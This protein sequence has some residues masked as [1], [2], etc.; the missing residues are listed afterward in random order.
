MCSERWQVATPWKRKGSRIPLPCEY[1]HLEWKREGGEK[2]DDQNGVKRVVDAG[3]HLDMEGA[4]CFETI[5]LNFGVVL[6]CG[7]LQAVKVEWGI[8]SSSRSW[9]SWNSVQIPSCFSYLEP[10][11][12]TDWSLNSIHVSALR[13]GALGFPPWVRITFRPR[14]VRLPQLGSAFKALFDEV[15]GN[16]L[17]M[18]YDVE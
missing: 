12:S 6:T 18:I 5:R 11:W 15:G 13:H 8:A 4:G 16:G 17:G 7:I 2:S 3:L 1:C 14:F 9:G 10:I